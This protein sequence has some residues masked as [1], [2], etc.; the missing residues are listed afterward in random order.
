[1]YTGEVTLSDGVYTANIEGLAE[2]TH[3]VTFTAVDKYGAA[4]S[5]DAAVKVKGVIKPEVKKL[6]TAAEV[7]NPNFVKNLNYSGLPNSATGNPDRNNLVVDSTGGNG[8]NSVAAAVFL[9]F[10]FDLQSM[11]DPDGDGTADYDITDM[12]L[13]GTGNTKEIP[14]QFYDVPSNEISLESM[15]KD[16]DGDG[17]ANTYVMP[18]INKT[19]FYATS[20]DL[21]VNAFDTLKTAGKFEGFT[22][23]QMGN[24]GA[25]YNIKDYIANKNGSASFMIYTDWEKTIFYF[26]DVNEPGM[27]R[28]YVR[29]AEKPSLQIL[30]AQQTYASEAVTVSVKAADAANGI[31]KVDFYANGEL[32]ATVTEGTDGV[33]T[34]DLSE[35]SM[36][37]CEIKAVAVSNTGS[38]AAATVNFNVKGSNAAVKNLYRAIISNYSEGPRIISVTK[39]ASDVKWYDTNDK[40]GARHVW[41]YQY[42][43]S[44]FRD[45]DLSKIESISMNM[46]YSQYLGMGLTAYA[47]K[48][49]Y[50]INEDSTYEDI[51]AAYP[52]DAEVINLADMPK[53]RMRIQGG[54]LRCYQC[55]KDNSCKRRLRNAILT[56]RLNGEN[57]GG[58]MGNVSPIYF[59]FK[60]ADATPDFIA[61]NGD[62]LTITVNPAHYSD[63]AVSVITA[64][65]TAGGKLDKMTVNT[66]PARDKYSVFEVEKTQ[67]TYKVL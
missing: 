61:D 23:G 58:K 49:D 33:Y 50:A 54:F 34:A 56:V 19:K 24:M 67:N 30:S 38:T 60:F 48:G 6:I 66:L 40:D 45:I 9:K 1:M 15:Y 32:K 12:Y 4:G 63:G 7:S 18:E 11:L 44:A 2:G 36:G 17:E 41:Y 22:D 10:D 28:L 35:L 29:L 65:Y 21:A 14:L 47:M 42:D 62:K 43:V 20:T 59:D 46:S 13:L 26:S 52:D 55:D 37:V 64:M 25:A 8:L 53:G 31:E 16:T 39:N 3:T 51:K 27:P 57:W 5:A